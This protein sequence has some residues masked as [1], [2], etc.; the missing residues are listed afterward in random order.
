VPVS[1]D[2]HAPGSVVLVVEVLVEPVGGDVLSLIVVRLGLDDV[3]VDVDFDVDV[4]VD[5]DVGTIVV[6]AVDVGGT[7][8]GAVEGTGTIV[9]VVVAVAA[10]VASDGSALDAPVEQ[11]AVIRAAEI[12]TMPTAR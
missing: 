4:D 9:V 8:G 5:V 12:V 7:V 11:P 6:V 3:D 2:A 10:A 1:D